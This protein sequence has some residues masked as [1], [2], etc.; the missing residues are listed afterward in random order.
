MAGGMAPHVRQPKV[1]VTGAAGFLGVHVA[2]ALAALGARLLL[3]DTAPKR[4]DLLAPVLKTGQAD[5][6]IG[7]LA[8]L[9]KAP[10]LVSQMA[11]VDYVVHLAL[12]VPTP[13][14]PETL[15]ALWLSANLAPLQ[16]LLN[17]LP[18]GL[19][20]LCLASSLAVYGGPSREPVAE[21][22]PTQPQTPL[23]KTKLA[24]ERTLLDYGRRTGTPVTVL[25]FSS[26]FGPGEQHA[27][28]VV[29]SFIRRLLAGQPP[30]IHG[31]GSD[32]DDYLYV[33]DAAQA[34]RRALERGAEAAGLYNIGA[35]H[36]WTTRAVAE[37]AQR[38]L[39]TALQ[40]MHMPARGP[41]HALIAD[42]SRA[43][44][45][46]GFRP[47]STLEAGLRAEIAYCQAHSPAGGEPWLPDMAPG[48]FQVASAEPLGR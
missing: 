6:V 1:L 22:C 26:L 31:D 19:Q 4:L 32:V 43:R 16:R 39:Q 10:A 21:G 40:P 38:V 3:Q 42:I 23:A 44:S 15:P 28:R 17:H 36:G 45:K 20:G 46:L 5:F 34:V 27:P 8:D 13:G 14:A 41:R 7:S 30:V 11:D 18:G 48:L 25:R 12:S 37:T 9:E 24:M 2:Q 33:E 47:E 29:P 35:G